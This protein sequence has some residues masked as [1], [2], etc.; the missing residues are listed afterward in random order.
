MFLLNDCNIY[1]ITTAIQNPINSILI[2]VNSKITPT[3][4]D[5]TGVAHNAPTPNTNISIDNAT[6]IANC[7]KVPNRDNMQYDIPT[8][9][10][11][12]PL[13]VI[14]IIFG[15]RLVTAILAL[16]VITVMDIH[17]GSKRYHDIHS[18]YENAHRIYWNPET[19]EMEGVEP[20]PEYD[21]WKDEE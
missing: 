15:I 7:G 20:M 2:L 5:T 12:T 4:H 19:K 21:K 10:V 1:N 13:I 14:A 16:V 11:F 6:Y 8:I 9:I 17:E 18:R 3:I